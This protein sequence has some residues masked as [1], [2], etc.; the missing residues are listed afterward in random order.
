MEAVWRVA[1]MPYSK[2]VLGLNPESSLGLS[3]DTAVQHVTLN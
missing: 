2:K 1:L 3:V